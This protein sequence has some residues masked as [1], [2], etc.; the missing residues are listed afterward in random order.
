M[1]NKDSKVFIFTFLLTVG[2][3]AL[4]LWQLMPNFS[5]RNSNNSKNQPTNN[6]Q[7][8]TE[9]MSFGERI[10]SPSDSSTNKKEG[11]QAIAQENYPQ[12]IA[13]FS[14]SLKIN[15]NDP[16][17][18][19]YL[20]NAKIGTQKNYTIFVSVPF[21]I[22]PKS[23]LEILR[24]VAQAQNEINNNGKI[25]GIPL[26]VGIAKD[27]DNPE[28]AQKIAAALVENPDVLGVVC[29][30]SSHVT[31]AA[32]EIYDSG[33]LVTISPTSTS[34]KITDFS[35]YV[36]R[37]VPSDSIAAR[38]LANYMIK[39][40]K[41]QKAAVFF[42]SESSYSQSLK[43]EFV[44]SVLLEGGEVSQ[45]FDLSKADFSAAQSI[46]KSTDDGVEVLMLA[47]NTL[48]LDKAL[49]VVQVNQ[50]QMELLAGDTTYTIK[51]L[52]VGREQALEM[53][54]AIPWH[55]NSNKNS[56]LSDFPA[57]SR[58]LWGADVNWRTALA[59]DATKALIK[60][61]ETD[62]T[63]EG[64]QKTLPSSDFAPKG[65]NG[66]IRFQSSG[67]RNSP[68]QLVKVVPGSRSRTGYDFEPID[69]N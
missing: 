56:L 62:P 53:V 59:Y 12:A 46:K 30:T 43:K 42:N 57:T 33:K 66:E 50:K 4:G 37:S 27:E 51:T 67:D 47:P 17:S 68:V 9:R 1:L 31:L 16:E 49:Q 28:T 35:P 63:R 44:T 64:I 55:I 6:D 54:V 52:E 65:A 15:P 3:L 45:E 13:D 18:L 8:V 20:N 60:A 23:A 34:V 2:I 41:K 24:G 25:K 11:S 22:N 61:I 7:S 69:N 29:C 26:K 38:T 58:R 40:L 36:F 48:T 21:G 39:N 32:G 5:G 14:K 19:I 10:F